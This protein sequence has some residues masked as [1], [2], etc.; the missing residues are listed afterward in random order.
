M[1]KNSRVI[2]VVVSPETHAK[3]REVAK[4]DLR[5]MKALTQKIITEFADKQF[6]KLKD[7]AND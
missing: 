5:T 2:N 1:S 6:A 4:A 3:L 7:Q